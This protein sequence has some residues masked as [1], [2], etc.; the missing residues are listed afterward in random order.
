MSV[1]RVVASPDSK[2]CPPGWMGIVAI[3]DAVLITAAFPVAAHQ[4]DC[5]LRAL[6]LVE[7]TDVSALHA[8]LPIA[9]VLGPAW[10]SYLAQE[11]LP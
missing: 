3:S 8:L 9:E 7:V 4:L 11:N 10:L 6:A 2:I 1:P 5:R